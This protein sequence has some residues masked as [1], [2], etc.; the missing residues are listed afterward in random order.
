MSGPLQSKAERQ[1]AAVKSDLER[2]TGT[3]SPLATGILNEAAAGLAT[4]TLTLRNL[5]EAVN[6]ETV[7]DKRQAAKQ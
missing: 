5:E 6:R 3:D 4:A 2:L 7:M 1:L